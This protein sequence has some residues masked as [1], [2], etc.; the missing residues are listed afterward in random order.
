M[1]PYFQCAFA[2]VN[3]I[4][5]NILPEK[6]IP[7]LFDGLTY[8]HYAIRNFNQGEAVGILMEFTKPLALT[9]FN[10]GFGG[11]PNRADA[12]S[13]NIEAANTLAD[14]NS[15]SGSYKSLLANKPA[16]GKLLNINLSFGPSYTAKFFKVTVRRTDGD[17]RVHIYEMM[18][19]FANQ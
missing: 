15:K 2:S 10:A 11:D 7:G 6:N 5:N 16:P 19:M 1:R 9:G 12:Y 17:R 4:P 8:P 3:T 18:P 14:L 13:V